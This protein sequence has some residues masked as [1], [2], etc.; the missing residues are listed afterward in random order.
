MRTWIAGAAL[1][2]TGITG[3]AQK[4]VVVNGTMNG[5]LKG[6]NKIYFYTRTTKDS[7]IIENGHYTW[8]FNFE[9]PVNIMLMPEYIQAQHTMYVPFGVLF[10]QPATY[11][12]TTNIEQGMESSV[13]TGTETVVLLGTYD[14]Q[15]KAAWKK[16]SGTLTAEFGKPWLDEKDPRYNDME[17]RRE[18][19]QQ[20]HLVPVLE[21]MV[22]AHP[23]AYAT[24]Y[25]LDGDGRSILTTAQQ[26][27]LYN[28][29]TAANRSSAPAKKFYNYIQGVKNS[30]PGKKVKDFSLPDPAGKMIPFSSL[31][32]KYILLDFWASWCSPCR[33]SFPRMR[34]VYNAY[35]DKNFEIL[36]ISIDE[37]KAGWLK[38]V[39]DEHNPWPQMLD[40]KKEIANGAFAITGVPT[41]YLIDPE[42]KIVL[43]EIGFDPAGNGTMEQKLAAI[44]GATVPVKKVLAEKKESV[45][46]K[47]IPMSN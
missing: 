25:L 8:S 6:H 21:K 41:T 29:L 34:E 33:Q 20:Q 16:I 27:D 2:L 13:V 9:E 18:A 22:T 3:T 7:A 39:A 31:K 45:P 19:L 10:D 24:A 1:L 32:G 47:A 30:A 11:T 28:K 12:V 4:K 37:S 17:K 43:K 14:K 40:N 5:D 26:E 23:D 15:K 44:F 36:S 38:A 35:K 46:M 42:G